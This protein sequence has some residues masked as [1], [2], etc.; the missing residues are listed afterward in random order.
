M[1]H[2]RRTIGLLFVA[3]CGGGGGA[4]GEAPQITGFTAMPDLIVSGEATQV[5]WTWGY[6]NDPDAPECEIIELGS[7]MESGGSSSITIAASTTYTLRCSNAAGSDTAVAPV[8]VATDP[9]APSIA[10]LAASP[11]QL[12]TNVAGDVTFTWTY[13][14]PPV[15]TPSCSLD[16]GIGVVTNGTPKNITLPGTTELVLTCM[17]SE[18]MDTETVTITTVAAPVAPNIATFTTNPTTVVANTATNVTFDWTYNGTPTPAATCEIDNGVGAITQGEAKSIDIAANTTYTLTC[19]NTAGSDTQTA[20]IMAQAQV[21]PDIAT[22]TADPPAVTTGADTTITW[23]WTYNGTP[24]PAATCEIDNG[25]G[26]M[27]NGGT[28]TINIAAD[29]LYTL[30]CTNAV[31][32]DTATLTITVN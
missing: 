5:T 13:T 29:T 16:Q 12:L 32:S 21:A 24:V 1:S 8:S 11:M 20:T 22:F 23:A 15:P 30:T 10:T 6:A 14:T 4:A 31:D 3:A 26:A 7:T 28:S 2:I 18:G 19:T 27:T 25:V 9:V 17:N